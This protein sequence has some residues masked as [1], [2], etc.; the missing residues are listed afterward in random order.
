MTAMQNGLPHFNTI[1][2]NRLPKFML[3][4]EIHSKHGNELKTKQGPVCR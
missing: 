4:Y 1:D 2:I 3:H